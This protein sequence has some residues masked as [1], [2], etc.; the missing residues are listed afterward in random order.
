MTLL[1][2]GHKAMSN[3]KVEDEELHETGALWCCH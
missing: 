3:E 2:G 1:N